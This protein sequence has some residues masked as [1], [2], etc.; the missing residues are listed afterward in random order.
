MIELTHYCGK[1]GQLMTPAI[2]KKRQ[3]RMTSR[4]GGVTGAYIDEYCATKC[5]GSQLRE[6]T[7]EEIRARKDLLA[8]YQRKEP[9][10]EL[11]QTGTEAVGR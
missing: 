3:R 8:R 9:T 2:C 6:A 1:Y 4:S 11:P 10:N 5:R 7:E